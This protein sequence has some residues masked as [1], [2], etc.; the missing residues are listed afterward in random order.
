M[1]EAK[2]NTAPTVKGRD[3]AAPAQTVTLDGVQYQ[4]KWG[5]KCARIAEDIYEEEFG[6]NVDYMHILVD[7]QMNKHRA[8]QA[9][10]FGALR[11]GGADMSWD[12]FDEKFTLDSIDQLREEVQ[13]SVVAMLPDP[14]LQG[15]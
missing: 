6:R 2:K 11:A 15:N 3:L 12:E 14:E 9:C 4:L 13:K 8:V 10:V 1:S 5:N 7:L